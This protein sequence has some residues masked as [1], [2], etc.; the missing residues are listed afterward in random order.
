[1]W[2]E[3]PALRIKK[4]LMVGQS[5]GTERDLRGIKGGCH[6]WSVGSRTNPAGSVRQPRASQAEL[7][8]SC[9]GGRLGA[10]KRG[11]EHD[12]GRDQMLAVKSEPEGTGAR[13]STSVEVCRKSPGY[14]GS[15]ARLL[16]GTQGWAPAQPLPHPLASS[17]P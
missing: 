5:A 9:P 8:A 16:N 3:V 14:R 15:Q 1:M 4:T 17:D 7:R 12:L 11:L 10:G 2:R 6:R 13:S